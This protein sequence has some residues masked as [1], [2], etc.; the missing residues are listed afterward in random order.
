MNNSGEPKV[1]PPGVYRNQTVDISSI[2]GL[3]ALRPFT[4]LTI[5]F[6]DQKPGTSGLRKKTAKFSDVSQHYLH[7]FVQATFTALSQTGTDVTCGSLLI[8]GD[9]RYFNKAAIQIIVKIAVANGVRRI[10]IGQNG[11]LSTPAVSAIIREKG[12]T[13]FVLKCVVHS[14]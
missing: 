11:L 14:S 5:P 1:L 12:T 6:Q 13:W 8:G 9:G 10:V 3:G 4:V 7:N 2:G